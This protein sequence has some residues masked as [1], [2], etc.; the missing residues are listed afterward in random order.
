MT[1]QQF[2]EATKG[3][4]DERDKIRSLLVLLMSA[5]VG[6]SIADAAAMKLMDQVVNSVKGTP[7]FGDD[8]AL[9][10]N[11]GY[12][13]KSDRKSGLTRKRLKKPAKEE[14]L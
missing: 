11:L 8:C 13:C 14:A 12:I 6:R 5:R 7:E 2:E 10:Q 4:T 1:L 9:Y 3:C